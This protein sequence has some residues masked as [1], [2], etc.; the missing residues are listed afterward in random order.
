MYLY[1]PLQK[2]GKGHTQLTDSS[3]IARWAERLRDVSAT[4]L[5]HSE[6][7]YDRERY[8]QMQALAQ[9][10]TAAAIGAAVD[11]FTPIQNELFDHPGPFVGADAAIFDD[12]DRILLIRRSDNGLWAMPGGASETGEPPA[13]T[14]VRE[15][16][17]ETGVGCR[18]ISLIG[19]Y[20]NRLWG[21]TTLNH[22]YMIVFL[23]E[24]KSGGDLKS[25]PSHALE[26]SERAWFTF[27]EL[28]DDLDPRH[29]GRIQH[30][31][32]FRKGRMPAYFDR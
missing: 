15:A 3:D 27:E 30:A 28:P 13:E 1:G 18:P 12:R 10:M 24:L 22:V 19:I 14:A 21:S 11:D 6:I 9:E 25:L 32:E 29:N 16:L 20:D 2:L 4:G 26:V 5:F 8:S 17:E 31:F 23:C 7:F